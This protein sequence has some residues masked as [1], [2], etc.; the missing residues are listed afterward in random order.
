MYFRQTLLVPAQD[1]KNVLKQE[2]IPV[3]CVPAASVATT[4]CHN[5][6]SLSPSTE[7]PLHRDPP[8]TEIPPTVTFPYPPRR[9]MGPGTETPLL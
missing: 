6:G 9:N 8:F 4:R 7:T 5:W 1:T 2:C 3:D